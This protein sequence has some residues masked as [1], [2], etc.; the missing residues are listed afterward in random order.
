[1]E[2]PGNFLK[3]AFS[4]NCEHIVQAVCIALEDHKNQTVSLLGPSED[5]EPIEQAMGEAGFRVESIPWSLNQ[6]LSDI[7]DHPGLILL[8]QVPESMEEWENVV[9]LQEAYQDKLLTLW[10][11][12]YP[13]ATLNELMNHYEFNGQS[14]KEVYQFYTAKRLHAPGV[15]KLTE[16]YDFSGKSVIEFGPSDGVHTAALVHFG[17]GHI[18]AVEGQPE[19]IIKLLCAKH[20][21]KWDHV[22]IIADNFQAKGAWAQKRYDLAYAH[23]VHYHC[24]NPFVFLDMLVELSDHIFLGGWA[25]TDKAPK[26]P[27]ESVEFKGETYRGKYF[28]EAQ[29]FLSG[30]GSQSFM[31]DHDSCIRFYEKRGFNCLPIDRIPKEEGLGGEFIR[32]LSTKRPGS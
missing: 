29:K 14:L 16:L 24:Q 32:F 21:F 26:G 5:T 3:N 8:C 27:W 12:T 22:E 20:V 11:Q 23:G 31:L 28:G 17:A 25:A 1:M 6:S 18:T 7:R 2:K 19:N 15:S 13:F 10:E 30:L 4:G 9:R